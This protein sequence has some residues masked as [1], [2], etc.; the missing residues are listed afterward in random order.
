M[1]SHAQNNGGDQVECI[2]QNLTIRGCKI[3]RDLDFKGDLTPEEMKRGINKSI[4]VIVFLT[5]GSLDRKYPAMELT[6]AIEKKKPLIVIVEVSNKTGGFLT[7]DDAVDYLKTKPEFYSHLQNI[8]YMYY[9]RR[10]GYREI[11]YT[12]LLEKIVDFAKAAKTSNKKEKYDYYIAYSPHSSDERVNIATELSTRRFKVF[13][14]NF[15]PASE[16]SRSNIGDIES[17]NHINSNVG[18]TL[19]EESI[20]DEAESVIF[21]IT[22]NSY[23][24][25]SKSLQFA[26]MKDKEVFIVMDIDLKYWGFDTQSNMESNVPV[27]IR[28]KYANAVID[29]KGPRC[30]DEFYSR[31]T[32]TR[33]LSIATNGSGSSSSSSSS[34]NSV[35]ARYSRVDSNTESILNGIT[36]PISW[37]QNSNP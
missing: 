12:S 29:Y 21:Y 19:S 14:S 24:F 16:M 20:I 28:E 8:N 4:C 10:Q 26:T 36:Q 6:H 5:K 22:A 9:E 35:D 15:I 33:T 31:L 27:E 13:N 1:I 37:R 30:N 7:M 23:P 18:E 32:N 11:F 2:T 34:S 25:I 17:G 3:W